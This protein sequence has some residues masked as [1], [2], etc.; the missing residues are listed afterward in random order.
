MPASTQ[1]VSRP[2]YW[3]A[4]LGSWSSGRH[5]GLA[6]RGGRDRFPLVHPPVAMHSNQRHG[7]DDDY[8][9]PGRNCVE[10]STN[11]AT[12]SVAVAVRNARVSAESF[13]RLWHITP[14]IVDPQPDGIPELDVRRRIARRQGDGFGED[15]HSFERTANR[16]QLSESRSDRLHG[17]VS[18]IVRHIVDVTKPL[19]G[20]VSPFATHDVE[21]GYRRERLCVPISESVEAVLPI[22]RDM[23]GVEPGAHLPPGT[24]PPVVGH[25]V[26]VSVRISNHVK[27]PTSRRGRSA[28]MGRR[29]HR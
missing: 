4:D 25:D 2:R 5:R 11:R 1:C 6:E 10:Q 21:C 28:R 24:P 15:G 20:D 27:R 13:G 17:S 8:R 7:R 14:C 3:Y 26:A 12:V 22:E 9:R 29:T 18:G 19:E 23:P 16:A